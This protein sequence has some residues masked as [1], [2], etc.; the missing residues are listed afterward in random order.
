MY[1]VLNNTEMFCNIKLC[2]EERK[3]LH[4][5]QLSCEKQRH[6]PV[7]KNRGV[8]RMKAASVPSIR[9]MIQKTDFFKYLTCFTSITIFIKIAVSLTVSIIHFGTQIWPDKVVWQ[10]GG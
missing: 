1:K 7:A 4:V 6:I 5:L 3:K 9:S 10:P 8:R 2:V